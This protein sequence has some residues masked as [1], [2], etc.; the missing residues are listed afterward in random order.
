MMALSL[1]TVFSCVF[2]MPWNF[3]FDMCGK[4]DTKV[5]RPFEWE[6]ELNKSGVFAMFEVHR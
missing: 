4:V 3:L 5:N 1:Q 2:F 6:F